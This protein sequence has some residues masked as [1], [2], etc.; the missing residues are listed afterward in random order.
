MKAYGGDVL[1]IPVETDISTS[2]IIEKINTISF[3]SNKTI[4]ELQKSIY[5]PTQEIKT[6]PAIFLDRDGTINKDIEYLHESEKFQLIPNV[7]HGLK[8]MQNMGY[9]LIIITNQ[10]GIGLGYFTKED[11][12]SVNRKMFRMFSEE[13]IN[14]DKIYFCPHNITDNCDCR[15]PKTGLIEQAK[16]DLN[17]DWD[18]SYMI[19]DK[20]AD[21]QTG[22]NAGL[23]TILVKTGTAGKDREYQIKSDYVAK[24]L[25]DAA[26]WILEQER[27]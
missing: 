3:A 25:L 18:H 24:N 1:L 27:K 15:K 4:V 5:F 20:T 8:K 26:N 19:G 22:L 6:K 10:A 23:K 17:L 2:K 12:Y 7:L 14:I 16:K 21:I 13:S 9:R 11:F